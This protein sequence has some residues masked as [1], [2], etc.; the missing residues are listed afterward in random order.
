MFI[1]EIRQLHDTHQNTLKELDKAIK[2]WR[3]ITS[4]EQALEYLVIESTAP[5]E[6]LWSALKCEYLG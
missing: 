6:V 2:V 1:V 4:D 5:F 3:V